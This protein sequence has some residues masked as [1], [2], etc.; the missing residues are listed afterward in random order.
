MSEKCPKCGKRGLGT[1]L[2]GLCAWCWRDRWAERCCNLAIE[3][4]KR[5]DELADLRRQLATA[6]EQITK[7]REA[8]REHRHTEKCFNYAVK[9]AL[10]SGCYYCI[11]ECADSRRAALA[12][13]EPPK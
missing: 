12:D 13:T 7:L 2:D 8:L 1:I 5:K 4:A 11:K 9:T 6:K 10:K 3:I